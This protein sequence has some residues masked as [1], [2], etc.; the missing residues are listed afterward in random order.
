LLAGRALE[1]GLRC[2][3]LSIKPERDRSDFEKS[4]AA[5]HG[6][7]WSIR[8]VCFTLQSREEAKT[9]VC[10]YHIIAALD[11]H[12]CSVEWSIMNDDA[13]LQSVERYALL[14]S[15]FVVNNKTSI[16]QSQSKS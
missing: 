2:L 13:L 10:T 9:T 3:P 1:T 16:T 15:V 6:A 11:R 8:E 4:S 7:K 14:Q 5:L 12:G